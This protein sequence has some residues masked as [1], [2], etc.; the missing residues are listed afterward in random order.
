MDVNLPPALG[1]STPAADK[2]QRLHWLLSRDDV[3]VVPGVFDALTAVMAEQSGF[4]ALYLTGAGLA[5]TQL[6]VPDVGVLQF[7]LISA[8]LSRIVTTTTVPVIV[9]ADTG[10]GGP[11]SVMYVVHALESLGAAA[12]QIEDQV[13][14]KRCGHFE[15]KQVVPVEEMQAKIDAAV[16]ARSDTNFV[17]IARTDA[18]APE[19]IDRA[20]SRARAY[21]QAGADVLFVEAPSSADEV[22]QVA[23]A[24]D[25]MPLLL[26]MVEGGKTP[27]MARQE[28]R[29]LGYRVVLHANVLMRTMAQAGLAC[30]T[31]LRSDEAMPDFLPWRTRQELVRLSDFN[32]L[33]ESFRARWEASGTGTQLL[34]SGS[35][36]TSSPKS[37]ET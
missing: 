37:L 14:P 13:M 24:L 10:F 21:R 31:A 30:L 19:G 27:A 18:A 8:Q 22:R 26:N 7:D 5:N 16:H 23:D 34:A 35:G 20:I 4:E 29:S 32:T 6:A 36:N 25:G 1:G 15:G 12:V 28:L 11:A 2:R 3:T 17:I 33:E 9:D